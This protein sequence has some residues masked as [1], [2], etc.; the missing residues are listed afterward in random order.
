M[1]VPILDDVID[2]GSEYFLLRF[3]NPQGATLDDREV[4]GLIRNTDLIPGA[5]L[6]RFGRAMAEQVVT[7]I[8]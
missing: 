4:E 1:S 7:R 6:A 3:S 5:L 8:E 2:E